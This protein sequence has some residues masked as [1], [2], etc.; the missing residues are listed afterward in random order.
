LYL[1]TGVQTCALPI[2]SIRQ[3]I[4]A[5]ADALTDAPAAVLD[6]DL[7]PAVAL[8]VG[9]LIVSASVVVAVRRLS[10]FEIRGETA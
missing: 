9:G 5:L 8:I 2:F 10:T 3:H 4:L 6:A 1:V 7:E